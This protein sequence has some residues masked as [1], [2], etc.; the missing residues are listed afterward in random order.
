MFE[1]TNAKKSSPLWKFIPIAVA[2]VAVITGIVIYLGQ[3]E[4]GELE[5]LSGIIRSDDSR[6]GWYSEYVTLKD[7]Q[8]QM[9]LNY[10]GNRVVMLSGVI[11]N[12][13]ERTLDV[14]ELKVAFFNYEEPVWE[15]LRTPVRPGP[16][17]PEIPPLTS[18]A[19][20]FY[21]EKI[22]VDWKSS[23]AEMSLNGFRFAGSVPE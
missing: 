22:P 15:T 12:A 10:A 7:P 8:I 1:Q 5:E 13:G 17:T 6:F 18:R 9:G 3:Y 23:H 21:I 20:S 14:V 16:Y 19:F 4:K 2:A 11:E